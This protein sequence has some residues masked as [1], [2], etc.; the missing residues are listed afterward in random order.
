[1]YTRHRYVNSPNVYLYIINQ[2]DTNLQLK[3][4]ECNEVN[5]TVRIRYIATHQNNITGMTNGNVQIASIG[6][7]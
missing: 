4:P 6:P 5:V 2:N 1:M 7:T 3:W